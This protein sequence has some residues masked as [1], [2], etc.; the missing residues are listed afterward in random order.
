ME[1]RQDRFDPEEIAKFEAIAREWWDPEGRFK[2][3]HRINPL[4][5]DYIARH[6]HL[7]GANVLDVG[8]GGG[9]LAEALA[10]RGARITGIDRSPKSLAVARLHAEGRDLGVEYHEA[11]AEGWADR[12]A[13][14][15]D[16]VTCLEVLEHVPDVP[17]TVAACARLLKPGGSFFFATINRTPTAW[18]KAIL[19]AEY[20]LG[21]LPKGTHRY[22]RLIRPSEMVG[23]LRSAGLELRDLAGMSYAL[24][25][26]RFELSDDLSVNYLGCA[27]KPA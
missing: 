24:L 16:V 8:C 6:A 26:D 12:H 11:D 18:L 21:W 25:A 7:E 17:A 14:E 20:I 9:L 4:R 10:G 27:A 23:A 5:V 3:L 15:Y 2:P 1:A 22:E 19:G 13:G